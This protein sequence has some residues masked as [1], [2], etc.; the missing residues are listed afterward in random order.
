MVVTAPPPETGTQFGNGVQEPPV[1]V[2]FN[3]P[4]TFTKP[5]LHVTGMN[6][7]ETTVVLSMPSVGKLYILLGVRVAAMVGFWRKVNTGNVG[8]RPVSFFE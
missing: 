6:A 4:P 2:M 5:L 1:H 8:H 3:G 7:P